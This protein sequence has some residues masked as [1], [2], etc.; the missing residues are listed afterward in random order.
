MRSILAR[1]VC[2]PSRRLCHYMGMVKRFN[3]FERERKKLYAVAAYTV[4][5]VSYVSVIAIPT[6]TW[7][8]SY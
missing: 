2:A 6:V 8:G 7:S 3:R 4:P 5:Y 1:V